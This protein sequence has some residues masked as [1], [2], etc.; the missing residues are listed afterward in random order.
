MSDSLSEYESE[1]ICEEIQQLI[2]NCEVIHENINTSISTLDNIEYLITNQSNNK[3][4]Y[5]GLQYNFD[6]VLELLHLAAL[7]NIKE[8]G[9][10][11]FGQLLKTLHNIF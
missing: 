2:D 1:S 4:T 3:V 11:N 6:E 8:N 7:K 9:T 10:S 5:N